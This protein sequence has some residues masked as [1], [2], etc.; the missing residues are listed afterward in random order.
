MWSRGRTAPRSGWRIC[1]AKSCCSIFGDGGVV[2]AS[3]EGFAELMKL[4]EELPTK[5]LVIIG[6]HTPGDGADEVNS[7]N[8][9]DAKLADVRQ[10]AWGGKDITFP[11]ALTGYRKGAYFP[12]GP[13][14]AASKMCVD[15]GVDSFPTA[16]LIDRNGK[17]VGEFNASNEQDRAMLLKIDRSEMTGVT[18]VAAC[19]ARSCPRVRQHHKPFSGE[20]QKTAVFKNGQSPSSTP[21]A[22]VASTV[23]AIWC[24]GPK[25]N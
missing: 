2:P 9:L 10:K 8:K 16:I 11:V 18:E 20:R 7:V 3:T 22:S 12:G 1:K 24:V 23:A 14:T 5:D 13:A 21:V 19:G 4:R 25:R 17:V 6:V 15:Y